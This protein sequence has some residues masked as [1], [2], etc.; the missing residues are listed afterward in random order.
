MF[1]CSVKREY[2]RSI[3]YEGRSFYA[4]VYR[5]CIFPLTYACASK[6]LVYEEHKRDKSYLLSSFP[7][8]IFLRYP[9]LFIC[10]ILLLRKEL[11]SSPASDIFSIVEK[12][13]NE[14]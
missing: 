5:L 9:I 13:F 7:S 2:D 12:I 4:Q 10:R 11:L 8:D 6:F 3:V 14:A 1:A